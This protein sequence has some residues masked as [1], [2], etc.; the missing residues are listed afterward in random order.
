MKKLVYI[1]TSD[2]FIIFAFVISFVLI[3][4]FYD[5]STRY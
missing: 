5:P 4:L 2:L 3:A 1:L